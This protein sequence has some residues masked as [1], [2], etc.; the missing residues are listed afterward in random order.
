MTA[1]MGERKARGKSKKQKRFNNFYSS[2]L[3][4]HIIFIIITVLLVL[5]LS[6]NNIKLLEII[7]T[8][9]KTIKK[10]KKSV[11]VSRWKTPKMKKQ[12]S[13]PKQIRTEKQIRTNQY[14]NV[15]SNQ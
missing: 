5:V 13:M 9:C 11:E 14:K 10:W 1:K 3:L 7:P 12:I 6:S 2:A 15:K 4:A 8:I